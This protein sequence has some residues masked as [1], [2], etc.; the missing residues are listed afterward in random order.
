MRRFLIVAL[1]LTLPPAAASA[2]SAEQDRTS[3]LTLSVRDAVD[4]A[5]AA[6][7]NAQRAR[8]QLTEF[9][10]LVRQA[11]SEALPRLELNLGYLHS[12]DPGFRNSPQFSRLTEGPFTLPPEA[13]LP[14]TLTNYLYR[15]NVEQRL[16][17]FG[18]TSHAINGARKELQGIGEDVLAAEN[19]AARAAARACFD[20]LLA[21][22]RLRVLQTEHTALERQLKQVQDRAELGD[23]TRLDVLRA[24]VA[25]A[26]LRPEILAAEDDITETRA[27]LNETLGRPVGAGVEVSDALAIPEPLP[28]IASAEELLEVAD[29]NRPELRR[30]P[31]SRQ[32]IDERAAFARADTLPD[33]KANFSWG[34]DTYQAGNLT[35]LEFRSWSAGFSMSWTIFDGRSSASL[36]KQLQSQGTQSEHRERSFRLALARELESASG[37]WKRALESAEV[38][39][40]AVEQAREAERVAEESYRWGAA[41]TLDL[42]EAERGLRQAELA[43][44]RAAHQALTALAELKYLVGFRADDPHL[45]LEQPGAAPRRRTPEG[46]AR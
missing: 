19:E 21:Q 16:Y 26:N 45:V 14:F 11:W 43:R 6:N 17:A 25:L 23:A 31:L 24:K 37:E 46:G 33:L 10:W 5:V 32:V 1:W 27:R 30:F 3:L 15:I 36:I 9:R 20:L 34:V 40:V 29:R 4:R 42:L 8:E 41:T 7:P 2:G 35:D 28:N 13:F 38:A 39:G 44:A 22:S 18:R 12:R